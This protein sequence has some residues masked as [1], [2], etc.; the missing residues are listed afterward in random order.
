MLY[1]GKR[2]PTPDPL[3]VLA[4]VVVVGTIVTALTSV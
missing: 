1:H 4:V 2:F 3:A